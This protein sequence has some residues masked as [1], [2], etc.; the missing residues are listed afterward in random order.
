MI[1]E[2]FTLLQIKFMKIQFL[3]TII[4]WNKKKHNDK[5]SQL[6]NVYIHFYFIVIDVDMLNGFQE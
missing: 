1:G 5:P 3:G 2:I 6:F 4:N